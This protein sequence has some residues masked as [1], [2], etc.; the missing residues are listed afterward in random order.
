MS[1][2][3]TNRGFG[4]VA[5][6]S[7]DYES[8][9]P[10]KAINDALDV[11]DGFL[12]VEVDA[13]DGAIAIKEG[14]VFITKGS[15]AALTLAAP[16]SGLPSAGTPGDDGKVLRIVGTTTFAHTVTT[17]SNKINGNKHI[18]TYANAGDAVVL[19]AKGGVW[20]TVANST[21]LS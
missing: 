16:T 6:T 4:K 8:A 7:P 2:P 20:Y 14:T 12:G 10:F 9:G 1:T 11:I 5:T 19:A 3:T 21:T 15:A 18:A 13:V 17:P